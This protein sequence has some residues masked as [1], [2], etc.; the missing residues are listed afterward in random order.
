VNLLF[1]GTD[2]VV[3]IALNPTGTFTGV[4][5][6]NPATN[7]AQQV[8]DAARAN[9]VPNV[10]HRI[11]NTTA[12]ARLNALAWIAKDLGA[13][14]ARTCGWAIPSLFP[15]VTTVP[16]AQPPQIGD[17]YILETLPTIGMGSINVNGTLPNAIL[18]FRD[19]NIAG[20]S[21]VG[22]SA[23]QANRSFIF[24]QGCSFNSFQQ[25]G[26]SIPI[27]QECSVT[28]FTLADINL[29]NIQGGIC[30]NGNFGSGNNGVM[31]TTILDF[32]FLI[33]GGSTTFEGPLCSVQFNACGIFDTGG[34]C[35]R[36]FQGATGQCTG[37]LY[38]TCTTAG[39][40]VETGSK[41]YVLGTHTPTI[42]GTGGLG[43]F[44]FDEGTFTGR[45][46]ND[47]T[48]IYSASI[49]TT[50]ANFV[51]AQPAGFGTFAVCP[52][53]GSVLLKQR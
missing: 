23:G 33:Q 2:A 42:T 3:P 35:V 36:L 43:D 14:Q 34:S 21:V 51:A 6:I 50:W 4:T 29:V 1:A 37:T 20:G 48:G 47:G 10:G 7:Q 16:S 39:V 32:D 8:A 13:N 46:F 17:S 22:S 40:D 38:G 27:L 5:A 15:I 53:T 31:Q 12:G 24:Y 45:F 19:F 28:F 26:F 11:R 30:L 18:L 44:I 52:A 25:A 49:A 41:F 9:W